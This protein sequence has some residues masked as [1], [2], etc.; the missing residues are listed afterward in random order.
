MAAELVIS[1]SF[2]TSFR[3]PTFSRRKKKGTKQRV[4]CKTQ[5]RVSHI[6]LP[7]KNLFR[8][9]KKMGKTVCFSALE[10]K[11]PKFMCNREKIRVSLC[12]ISG[13]R[14]KNRI[15]ALGCCYSRL[16]FWRVCTFLL[17]KKNPSTFVLGL[18][19]LKDFLFARFSPKNV[20]L[21][22]LAPGG[23]A[24]AFKSDTMGWRNAPLSP[25][26]SSTQCPRFS[27]PPPLSRSRRR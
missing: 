23:A 13:R 25:S 22:L 1:F 26:A 15:S 12:L 18:R 5:T 9:L 3:F 24:G 4:S 10:K 21:L 19:S 16:E 14:K 8:H 17:K 20:S 27:S 6:F 7:R 2:S 11:R